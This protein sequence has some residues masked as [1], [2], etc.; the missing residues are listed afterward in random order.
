MCVRV[1][2]YTIIYLA[3][4]LVMNIQTSVFFV[5]FCF[6]FKI[7]AISILLCIFLYAGNFFPFRID[8]Q[9]YYF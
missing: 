6:A 9:K 3:I 8:F 2:V 5:L 7:F 1:Y 4:F